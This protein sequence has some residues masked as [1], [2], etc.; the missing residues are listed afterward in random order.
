MV[1]IIIKNDIQIPIG[2]HEGKMVILCSDHRGFG[3]KSEMIRLLEG[4][5][6]NVSDIGTYSSERC[7]YPPLSSEMGRLVSLDSLHT[8]GIGI[9]G[10]GIGILIP[11]SKY[12]SVHVARCL[13]PQ[14]AQTSRKHNNTNVLGIGADC[15]DLETAIATV[16]S[17]LVTPFYSDPKTDDAYLQRYIQT[18]KLE[19]TL[20]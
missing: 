19:P 2:S 16:K 10:S 14:E 11:S 8:L 18:I 4:D 3:Y 20:K 6:W 5:A 15:V 17:W 1:E 7:D 9:C 12:R 13:T